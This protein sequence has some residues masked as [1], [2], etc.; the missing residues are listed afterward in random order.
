MAAH[1]ATAAAQHADIVVFLEICAYLG[2][3]DAWVCEDLDEPT[4]ASMAAACAHS[5]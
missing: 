1:V 3:P 5:V 2:V 4:V